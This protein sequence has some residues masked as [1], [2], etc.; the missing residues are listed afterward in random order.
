[1]TLY[2]LFAAACLLAAPAV[3]DDALIAQ[4]RALFNDVGLSASGQ[5]S[6]ATCHPA[7]NGFEGHTN[8][9]TYVG[10]DV[11]ADGEPTGR[12]TPTMWMAGVRSAWGWAGTAP[13]LEANIRGIIVNR[14]K[15]PEPTEEQLAA[16]ATYVSQLPAPQSGHVDMDGV[17]VD[18]APDAVERGFE[19]FIG[20]GGCGTCHLIGSFDK[21]D[22]EDV[23]TGG[24][25][26]VPSLWAVSHTGP[27]FHDGRH[28]A[29][30][31]AARYMWEHH[32]E[33]QGTPSSPTDAQLADLVAYLEAL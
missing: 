30:Q 4:G 31:D 26:K 5:Y 18:G 12:S 7:V 29:L 13:S 23:G 6:C 11:V 2:R 19:L 10:L 32:H 20:D 28:A 21:A 22:L 14:M 27:W 25:F 33:R 3:A 17:P 24:T 8:N 1:M 9:H 15:G 16:L